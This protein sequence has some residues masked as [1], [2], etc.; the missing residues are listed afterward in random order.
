MPHPHRVVMAA[1]AALVL[2]S[3]SGSPTVAPSAGN[4]AAGSPSAAPVASGSTTVGGTVDLSQPFA[5]VNLAVVLDTT[6]QAEALVPVTGGSVRASGADGTTY[7]LDIPA[8]ALPADTTIRLTPATS[9]TGLPFGGDTTYAVQMSPNGLSLYSFATLTIVP[10]QPVPAGEQ[11]AFGYLADGKD[12]IAAAPVL[13]TSDIK[14]RLLHFS[15]AGVTNGGTDGLSAIRQSLGGDAERRIEGAINHLLQVE[16]RRQLLGETQEDDPNVLTTVD[17]MLTQY[18]EE[19]VKQRIAAA[20]ASC[21]AGKLAVQTVVTVG[22]SREL[23]GLEK[24]G[25]SFMEEYVDVVNK[26]ARACVVEE[27]EACVQHHRIFLMLPIYHSILRQQ[28]VFPVFTN[29]TLEEAQDL[30]VKCLTFKLVLDSTANVGLM[31]WVSYSTVTAEVTLRFQ[32]STE[33]IRGDAAYVNTK[34]TSKMPDCSIATTPGGGRIAV[35]GLVYEIAGGAPDAD[36]LYPDAGVSDFKLVYS[37]E[38]STEHTV[39]T[40]PN[41]PGPPSV[42]PGF[43]PVW[44]LCYYDARSNQ[45]TTETGLTERDWVI[46]RG[47]ELMADKDW[48]KVGQDNPQCSEKGSFEIHHAPGA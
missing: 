4:P 20:G 14:I 38:P 10:A 19:V 41:P 33:L 17:K 27:F 40:C 13:H 2:A 34:F 6:H 11:I 9:V 35:L 3:C 7:T 36:G 37:V 39:I 42:I 16:R 23:L 43:F 24:P 21:D 32:P 22:R 30:T 8:D 12:V 25:T 18:E 44:S 31:G 29:A 15:G 48:T 28:S 26:A 5:P 47:D 1:I 46:H 45:I